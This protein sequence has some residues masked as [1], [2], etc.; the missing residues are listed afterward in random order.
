VVEPL[1][2]KVPLTFVIV[3]LV[4]LLVVQ[5]NVTLLPGAIVVELA[6]KDVTVGAGAG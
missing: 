5:V 6:V 3:T 4:A 1:A 2:A